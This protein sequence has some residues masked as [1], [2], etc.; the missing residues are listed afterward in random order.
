MFPRTPEVL[1]CRG[2]GPVDVPWAEGVTALN[3]TPANY[4]RDGVLL[5]KAATEP[6]LVTGGGNPIQWMQGALRQATM[7]S[8][9]AIFN[10]H[11]SQSDAVYS[12]AQRLQVG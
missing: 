9:H 10:R 8:F 2:S 4:V 3:T 1:V 7:N 5:V 11:L 6:G 12:D